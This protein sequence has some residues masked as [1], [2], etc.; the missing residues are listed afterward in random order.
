MP[1][2]TNKDYLKRHHFLAALW[3]SPLLR[4]IF[5]KLEVQEQFDLHIYYQTSTKS[6]D[7]EL[8]QE[9]SQHGPGD[10]LPQ[11]AGRAWN[12]LFRLYVGSCKYF[13]IEVKEEDPR[14]S[15]KT[16]H[17]AIKRK[18]PELLKRSAAAQRIPLHNPLPGKLPKRSHRIEA[19]VRPDFDV[20][21]FAKALLLLAMHNQEEE[22]KRRQEAEE[23]GS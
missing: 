2:L 20:E 17:S 16:F 7:E 21:G 11:K 3:E 1:R 22:A 4:P 15:V 6:S 23:Q 14:L 9:R 18:G 8:L 10:S 12:S 13:G 19:L 5:Q